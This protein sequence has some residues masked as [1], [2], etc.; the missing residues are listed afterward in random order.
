MEDKGLIFW[1]TFGLV[2]FNVLLVLLAIVAFKSL[3]VLWACLFVAPFAFGAVYFDISVIKY[4]INKI[5]ERK[6]RRK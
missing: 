5:K 2:A 1:G 6:A 4:F 3:S